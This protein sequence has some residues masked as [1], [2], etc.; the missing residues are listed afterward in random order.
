[1][2]SGRRGRFPLG[3]PLLDAARSL[4]VYVE[5]VCG[6]RGLCGRCQV[7]IAEGEFAKHGIT[8]SAGQPLPAGRRRP[9][10]RRGVLR[11]A[12]RLSC[13]G[14][15][16]GDL[17]IDVPAEFAV[18]RQIVRKRAETRAIAADPATRLVTVSVPP[19]DMEH[20]LGDADRLV[21]AI[22]ATG[23]WRGVWLD[24]PLLTEVQRVL[25][26][27][28]WTVT[29]AVHQDIARPQVIALWPG[30]TRRCSGSR[31]TSARPP[32]PAIWWT[33]RAAAPWP[34]RGR[35]TRRSASAR[36]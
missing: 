25:R 21:A 6:G 7:E 15:V 11:P 13:A 33:S 31:S 36:I 17:V 14:R 29:A 8:S 30:G 27:G 3:T 32:S 1:M 19:P 16:L 20:P 26:A 10:A 35:R 24:P 28:D 22:E 34:R 4:G 12:R 18:N 2:P 5:S 23:E 9:D